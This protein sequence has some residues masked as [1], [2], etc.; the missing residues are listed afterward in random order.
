[1]SD[2]GQDI[3]IAALVLSLLAHVGIMYYMRPQI[4]AQVAPPAS[5][6][7]RTRGPMTMRDA[8]PTPE[9]IQIDVLHDVEALKD[10]P[11]PEA[12][13][14]L[15]A[16]E[17]FEPNDAAAS[18]ARPEFA[19][20][21][22][23]IPIPAAEEEPPL[24]ERFSVQAG[25]DVTATSVAP[26]TMAAAALANLAKERMAEDKPPEAPAPADGP[27]ATDGRVEELRPV[28]A[29][30]ETPALALDAT[31]DAAKLDAAQALAAAD[32]AAEAA[33][34]QAAAEFKPERE[35]MAKVDERI[36][37]AEKAAVREL[38]DVRNAS[39]L[40][41]FVEVGAQSAAAGD[42]VYFRVTISPGEGLSTIPK[43][44]VVLMD[45]SGSI[46]RDRL[47][48]CREAARG[49]LRSC[50]N[51]GDRFNLV[52]FRDRFSYAFSSWQEC[53][54]ESFER[55]DKWLNRLAAHGRTDVFATIRSV[56]T[57]PRDPSRPLIAVVVTD[58]D[59]NSGVSETAQIISRFTALNDG[60][61]SIYMYGVKGTAN[62]E[63]L[64]A[65]THG[66]RG[67]SLI[68]DGER[69]RAG[70]GLEKLAERFRDP[71]LSDLRVVFTA[72]SK[73]EIYPRRLRNLYRGESVTL[74]GRAPAG[75]KEVAFSVKGLN[76]AA[77]Y[78]G[79]FTIR[80]AGR[81]MF[82]GTIPDEWTREKETYSL[83]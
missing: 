11:Q 3:A 74:T 4:M 45:A 67:E 6:R 5:Q 80:L 58:G 22:L 42:W 50:T 81:Q 7:M 17:G 57:L 25:A 33:G 47:S 38:L 66:N 13:A 43:D 21:G 70:S 64:D 56:L 10:A 52:A 62:R 76:G 15:P 36:V 18:V 55:A 28:F 20:A 83:Y 60:L 53:G 72:D 9:S 78:E 39:E 2:H 29:L 14:P 49:I 79:F 16:V 46:G 1:M 35:V 59:A 19:E 40:E 27:A 54:A 23:E 77:P 69:Y 32:E 61:V 12:G 26:V 8:P 30:P 65:L 73:A 37:E 63:L 34:A 51:T 82:D 68:Y 71:V 41:N 75:T 44:L 31:A 24:S 48:S